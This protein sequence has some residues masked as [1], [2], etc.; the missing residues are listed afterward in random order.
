MPQKNAKSAHPLLTDV[1]TLRERA[2]KDIAS[3]AMTS[4]YKGDPKLSVKILQSVLATA[5]V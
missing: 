5:I 4:T 2:R 3:G 1:K